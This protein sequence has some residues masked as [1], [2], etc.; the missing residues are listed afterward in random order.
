MLWNG[1]LKAQN[2]KTIENSGLLLKINSAPSDR[3]SSGF[4][5]KNVI[6]LQMHVCKC[7][8]FF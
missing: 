4:A 2:L 3:S 6:K 7:V 8:T 5:E 1:Q